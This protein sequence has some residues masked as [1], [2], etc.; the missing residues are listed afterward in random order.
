MIA[1][2]VATFKLFLI[3]HQDRAGRADAVVVLSG[4]KAPRLG[5]A[6]DL[7]GRGVAPVLVISH[8]RDRSWPQA[9]RLCRH[10]GPG[11]RVVCFLPVP[12]ST[13]G[14]AQTFG[15]LAARRRWRSVLVV[16]STFHVTRARML[17][18]RCVDGRVRAVGASYN[19]R[20]VFDYV[21]S[22]WGKLA[23]ALTLHRRC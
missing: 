19:L 10:G 8:G 15:R 18:R 13:Q 2:V 9:N 1:W 7:M 17:F 5:K 21:F 11:F 20:H 23:Y 14:E 16:T 6:L 3:P 12:D 22:E 4:S